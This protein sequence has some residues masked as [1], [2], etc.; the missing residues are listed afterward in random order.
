M[1]TLLKIL[2]DSSASLAVKARCAYYI[3]EQTR[4]AVE[5]EDLDARVAQLE[6]S[7]AE[8]G[9]PALENRT[10]EDKVA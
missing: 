4:K 3:L 6:R 2:V 7:H 9:S 10:D 1:T 5:T 8:C